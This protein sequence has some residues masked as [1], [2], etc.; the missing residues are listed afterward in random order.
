[1]G[2]HRH[3]KA[4]IEALKKP[5]WLLV[6]MLGLSVLLSAS[7]ARHW[8]PTFDEHR[9]LEMGQNIVDDG[10]F[11]RF[12]N[13]KMPV[14]ALNYIGWK[15]AP[16][17]A[18]IEKPGSRT[19][20]FMAR[21]PQLLWLVGTCLVVF[22]W[23]RKLLGEWP[24]LGAAGLVAFD[25][26]LMAH[27]ALVTTDAP[28][29]F[30]VVLSTWLFWEALE[31]PSRKKWLIAGAIF[32]LAQAAK[33]TAVFLVPILLLLAIGHALIR[34]RANAFKS[35]GWFSAAALLALNLAYGFSG[36]FSS[37]K[38][39]TLK[40]EAFSAVQNSAIPLP[41]PRP[42]L[43]GLAWVESD[44]TQG[45]V[46]VYIDGQL[47]QM[48]QNDFYLRTIRWKF[49]L[50][51]LILPLIGL[52]GLA[53]KRGPLLPLLLPPIVLFTWFSIGFNYQ[54]G[55]RYILPI[56][57]FLAIWAAHCRFSWIR[58][59]LLWTFVSGL[60]WWPWGLSYMNLSA[61]DRSSGWQHLAD[62]NLDWGQG[63]YA[64]EEWKRENPTGIVGEGP[65]PVLPGPMLIGAN[66]LVGLLYDPKQDR[67]ACLREMHQPR[68]TIAGHLYEFNLTPNE[69]LESN[70]WEGQ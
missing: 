6:V 44:D 63:H 60:S 30:F 59:G 70:C 16:G 7:A 32:G 47:T 41:V 58:I 52:V 54:L 15:L 1:M 39:M 29:T 24:A 10:D 66:D 22:F 69:V 55:V 17:S 8:S 21:L 64:I 31:A 34:K 48:G 25:P 26:N 38:D 9:H 11:S 37:G 49:P 19:H 35:I 27:S 12:D 62:S 3:L 42:W 14:S 56:V 50:P 61:L 40:G 67:Y 4:L 36:T 2:P 51:L 20:W 57:P 5:K 65:M 45:Q 28:C 18:L 43:E 46:S 53:R 68:R 13:S 33:F 23:T